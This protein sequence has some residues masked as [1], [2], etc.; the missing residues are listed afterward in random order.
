M[1]WSR[2]SCTTTARPTGAR[3]RS[4]S[5]RAIAAS[6]RRSS[7]RAWATLDRTS[8]DG[9]T[10]SSAQ[11]LAAPDV[12]SLAAERCIG[13]ESDELVGIIGAELRERRLDS[14]VAIDEAC[15]GL[16]GRM[17][18]LRTRVTRA[19]AQERRDGVVDVELVDAASLTRDAVQREQPDSRNWV[20]QRCEEHT[21]RLVARVMIEH[22][23]ALATHLRARV[24]DGG[25]LHRVEGKRARIRLPRSSGATPFSE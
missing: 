1:A 15:D 24:R 14:V 12:A 4:S 23:Q 16:H 19:R 11:R 8:C 6:P 3:S 22:T 10:R 17:T 18:H 21:G 13:H 25:G 9:L 5:P 7:S 20:V 2:W